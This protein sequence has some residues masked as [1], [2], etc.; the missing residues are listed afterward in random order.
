[1]NPILPSTLGLLAF[2]LS[3]LPLTAQNPAWIKFGDE[4]TGEATDDGHQQWSVVA[5]YTLNGEL[6]VGQSGSFAFNKP[7]DS[8]SPSLFLAC[9]EGTIFPE[10][11]LD[12]HLLHSGEFFQLVR[13]ELEEVS[14]TNV[15]IAGIEDQRPREGIH[16]SFRKISYSYHLLGSGQTSS[17]FD[18]GTREGFSDNGG[19]SSDSDKDGMPDNWETDNK[20][21]VGVNDANGDA[22][23]DQLS[24]I[25]EY[26][27]GTDPNS[28]S[29]F[30]KVTLI[31]D[32]VSAEDDQ[33]TWNSRSGK[34][35]LV[36]WSP[37]LETP[38]TTIQTVTA[39]GITTST[40]VGN[41][42]TLGYFR[43]RLKP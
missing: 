15:D 14:I 4:I 40:K 25:D 1:M 5:G 42:A 19:G 8:A 27:L 7:I 21:N 9:A 12:L 6:A 18:Y 33:L 35:Y 13:I 37:D 36:E 2:G 39:S 24:N 31:R 29:S 34:T 22:D 23:H 38:F 41:K 10:V 16:L 43:V 3:L 28:G 20:L 32:P 26:R 30:F 11:I 17:N